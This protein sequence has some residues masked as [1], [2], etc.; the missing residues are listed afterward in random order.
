MADAVPITSNLSRREMLED[1]IEY[2]IAELD[3][4]DGDAELECNGDGELDYENEEGAE[5]EQDDCRSSLVN[6]AGV[7]DWWFGKRTKPRPNEVKQV[8]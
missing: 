2:A 6:L 8:A 1:A 3:R 7:D 5:C 4:L